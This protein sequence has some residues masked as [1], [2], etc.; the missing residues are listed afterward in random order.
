[1]TYR[2]RLAQLETS[3]RRDDEDVLD[4]GA[5]SAGKVDAGLDG[6]HH[7]GLERRHVGGD[8]VRILEPRE[9][10]RVAAVVRKLP[11]REGREDAL[12]QV[13]EEVRALR[14]RH[15]LGAGSV[16]D[17]E[18]LRAHSLDLVVR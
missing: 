4:A 6:Q 13:A 10:D 1:M 12:L 16:E 14:T 2:E 7:P 3:V 5:V 15:E 17:R 9:A 11:A 18:Q 8:D